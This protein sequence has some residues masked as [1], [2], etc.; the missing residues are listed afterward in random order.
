MHIYILNTLQIGEPKE[1]LFC[2]FDLTPHEYS[3]FLPAMKAVWVD[4]SASPF[5]RSLYL[6]RH[7]YMKNQNDGETVQIASMEDQK[8]NFILIGG[9]KAVIGGEN[10]RDVTQYSSYEEMLPL[11]NIYFPKLDSFKLADALKYFEQQNNSEND[12]EF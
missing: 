3:D 9:K 10:I 6:F 2:T 8:L 5:Y 11:I 1:R 4:E 12:P 7:F